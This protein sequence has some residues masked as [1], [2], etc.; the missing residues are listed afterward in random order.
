MKIYQ[1]MPNSLNKAPDKTTAE[2]IRNATETKPPGGDFASV[3][4][5]ASTRQTAGAPPGAGGAVSQENLR[6]S[7]L[8][9]STDLGQAGELLSCL[10][11]DIRAATPEMLK[12]VHNLEGLIYVYSKNNA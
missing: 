7:Q 11:D 8:P 2:K 3:L 4:K 10:T 9:S 5:A 12:R 1:F 6:A